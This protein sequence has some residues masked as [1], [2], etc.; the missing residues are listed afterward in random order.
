VKFTHDIAVGVVAT[1][2][3]MAA[4][5][6]VIAD[7][8]DL[9]SPVAADV[10]LAAATVV[11][12]VAA[13]VAVPAATAAMVWDCSGIAVDGT[14]RPAPIVVR[15]LVGP[16]ADTRFSRD[17]IAGIWDADS[18]IANPLLV[19]RHVIAVPCSAG[20]VAAARVVA[21]DA[22]CS[23]DSEVETTIVVAKMIA[24]S[25]QVAYTALV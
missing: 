18:K 16:A 11:R 6:A 13:L 1:D 9:D 5:L 4:V 14:L 20:E 10:V 21:V 22:V 17:I 15:L 24:P 7:E 23:P 19:R 3:G 8:V 2:A 12:R 25:V